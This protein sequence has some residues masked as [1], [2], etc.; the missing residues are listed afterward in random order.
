VHPGAHHIRTQLRRNLAPTRYTA[1]GS[2]ISNI[3]ADRQKIL[4]GELRFRGNGSVPNR[5]YR[6]VRS[7]TKIRA[8][9][10]TGFDKLSLMNR[11]VGRPS[12]EG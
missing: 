4:A 11:A 12:L 6:W 10:G 3:Q 7:E 8:D 1:L 2:N 9:L 5:R